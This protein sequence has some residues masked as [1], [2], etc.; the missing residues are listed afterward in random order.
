MTNV[1][2]INCGARVN[3]MLVQQFSKWDAGPSAL[4]EWPGR[5]TRWQQARA[6]SQDNQ[7]HRVGISQE[8]IFYQTLPVILTCSED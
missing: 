2:D 5:I 7:T 3:T 1:F 6:G 8:S 4:E